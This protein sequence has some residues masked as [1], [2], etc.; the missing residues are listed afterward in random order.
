MKNR[1]LLLLRLHS[2][3][4]CLLRGNIREQHNMSTNEFTIT[5]KIAKHGSQAV[6]VVPKVLQDELKPHTV[7]K[8]TLTVL[9]RPGELHGGQ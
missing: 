7:V 8:L 3:V 1:L 5:K 9:K 2:P 4:I 6:I